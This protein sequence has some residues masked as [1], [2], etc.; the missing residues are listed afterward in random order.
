MLFL[1]KSHELRYV[2]RLLTEIIADIRL[3]R[4]EYEKLLALNSDEAN[5][6]LWIIFKQKHDNK[7][8]A[9]SCLYHAAIIALTN[10]WADYFLGTIV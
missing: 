5:S 6:Q 2:N 4:P 3:L 7:T 9:V 8:H 1:Q 10:G